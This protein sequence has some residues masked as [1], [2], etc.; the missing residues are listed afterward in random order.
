MLEQFKY[1]GLPKDIAWIA[2]KNTF[3]VVYAL[4]LTVIAKKS[5]DEV[6]IG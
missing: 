5:I 6:I 1:A 3:G 2:K 4:L